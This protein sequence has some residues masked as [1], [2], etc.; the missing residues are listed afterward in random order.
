M[1][2]DE[3]R[4]RVIRPPGWSRP[5]GYADGFVAVGSS[6]LVTSGQ[7][8]WDP[9]THEFPS[10][11]FADQTALALRNVVTVIEAAGAKATDVVRLTWFITSREEYVAAR[12]AIGA[13]YRAL[14]GQHYP[15]MSVVVVNGL[16][17]ER[18]KIEI[19]GMAVL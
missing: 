19:E 2:S 5:S 3:S 4:V 12:S 15:A 14:F 13:A 18:A 8:G 10:D 16:V 7:I 9:V 17:E 11:D 1:D 6:V